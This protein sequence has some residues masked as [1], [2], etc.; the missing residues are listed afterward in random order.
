MAHFRFNEEDH[1]YEVRARTGTTENG[2]RQI[3]SVTQVLEAAGLAPDFSFLDPFYLERGAAIHEA[4]ALDLRGE[5]DWTSLDDRIRPFVD[6]ARNW[7]DAIGATPLVVEFR[8]ADKIHGYAGT[9]DLFCES[10]LGPLLIDWKAAHID[11]A[12]AVQV[13]GGY[14]PLLL[15]AAEEGA[16]PVAPGDVRRA[17]I[18]IVNL[19]TEMPKVDWINR[20]NNVEIFRAALAV[21]TWRTQHRS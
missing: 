12:Y 13:A 20:D 1:R 17:R 4:V 3:P 19:K 15:Q 6:H 16:V 8:W 10:K 14:E 18:G 9:L 21:T 7:L 5:L 11:P 2:W